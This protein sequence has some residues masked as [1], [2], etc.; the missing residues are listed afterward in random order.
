MISRLRET[1][2]VATVGVCAQRVEVGRGVSIADIQRMADRLSAAI[3][4]PIGIDDARLRL[5]AFTSL[6]RVGSDPARERAILNREVDVGTKEWVFAQSPAEQ[7]GVF[8][9][10]ANPSVGLTFSR[11]GAPARADGNVVAYVWVLLPEGKLAPREEQLL[12]STADEVGEVLARQR[13]YDELRTLQEREGLLGLVSDASESRSDA[14]ERLVEAGL[15]ESDLAFNAMVL[16]P[17]SD[18]PENS[19]GHRQLLE[20]SVEAARLLFPSTHF[21]ASVRPGHALIVAGRPTDPG[22]T[23]F[24]TSNDMAA[25]ISSRFREIAGDIAVSS[26]V[27]IGRRYSSLSRVHDSYREALQAAQVAS[28]IEGLGSPIHY[29]RLGV[30]AKIAQ[31]SWDSSERNQLHPGIHA[32]LEREEEGDPLAQTLE[33]FL[34]NAG[35]ATKTAET[36]HLHR[37]SLYARLRRIEAVAGISLGDGRDRLVAHLELKL[38]RLMKLRTDHASPKPRRQLSR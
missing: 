10:P 21:L 38:A 11:W 5:L 15:F 16:L 24:Q 12:L 3:Q 32:L 2:V 7:R 6:D 29:D 30:Y 1:T 17:V 25:A 8:E 31:L 14:A 19:M 22:R 28:A 34:D 37:A 36:L 27:G 33:V 18:D 9:V 20:R 26:F 4:K 35:N 13:L 23:R